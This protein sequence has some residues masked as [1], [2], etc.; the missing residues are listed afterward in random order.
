MIHD[1]PMKDIGRNVA[2]FSMI[3]DEP[4]KYIRRNVAADSDPHTF[5][6]FMF[7]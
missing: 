4:M 7:V 6:L 3:H 2:R 5:V 1:E